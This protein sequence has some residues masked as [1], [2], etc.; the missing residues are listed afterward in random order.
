M[1]FVKALAMGLAFACS[2]LLK[3]I[4]L[5]LFLVVD[6]SLNGL[7]AMSRSEPQVSPVTVAAAQMEERGSEMATAVRV[8]EELLGRPRLQYWR[9]AKRA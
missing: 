7:R 1:V 9:M 5:E 2:L 8:S 3:Y 4:A 6:A